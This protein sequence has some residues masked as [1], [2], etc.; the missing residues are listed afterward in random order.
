MAITV[1]ITQSLTATPNVVNTTTQQNL[2]Q[3]AAAAA[4][5]TAFT[6]GTVVRIELINM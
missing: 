5:A 6:N 4:I 2:S 1:L 3:A